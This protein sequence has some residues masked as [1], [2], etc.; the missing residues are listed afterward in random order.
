MFTHSYSIVIATFD[1]R[2]KSHFVPLME[3]LH[4]QG[5]AASPE[6][7]VMVNGPHRAQFSDEYRRDILS[8]LSNYENAYP[9]LFPSFQSL[10]KLW[11]RGILTA[12]H[13]MVLVL[14]DDLRVKPGFLQAVD[15]EV[16]SRGQ[17]FIIN[18]SFSHYVAFKS[19]LIEVGFFDERLLG[20]GEEDGDFAWRFYKKYGRDIASVQIPFIHNI[21]SDTADPQVAKGIRK[22]SK[23]NREF[24]TNKKYKR[25]IFGHKG[26]F[27]HKVVQ[28][29]DD[30][31]QYPYESFYRSHLK[32]L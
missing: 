8:F 27:D 26:M 17:S 22:Y 18:G 14:N 7:I 23:F 24:I 28:Q 19:E 30:L 31:Q 32:D 16:R 21:E 13:E 9:T 10:S 3:D 25:S 6:I 2:F 15:E 1:L 29:I 4:R 12:Q 20:V 5:T 11:N